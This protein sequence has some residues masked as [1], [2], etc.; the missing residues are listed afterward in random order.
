ML[1][2]LFLKV[3]VGWRSTLYGTSHK[4][5]NSCVQF[6]ALVDYFPR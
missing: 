3:C 4:T 2:F 5:G 6:L 1:A